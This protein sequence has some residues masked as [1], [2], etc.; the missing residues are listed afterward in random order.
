MD[1]TT[2]SYGIT[3]VLS[4]SSSVVFHIFLQHNQI[5]FLLSIPQFWNFQKQPP[6][7][8][9]SSELSQKH[10]KHGEARIGIAQSG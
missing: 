1:L 7:V 4:P 10:E 6:S 8:A 2:N 9:Q 5:V 3:Y